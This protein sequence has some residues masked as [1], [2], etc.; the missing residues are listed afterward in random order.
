M[1]TKL[2][3]KY[4]YSNHKKQ[5]V[6]NLDNIKIVSNTTT[7]RLEKMG[8]TTNTLFFFLIVSKSR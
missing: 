2:K 1:S 7:K 5:N 4:R 3:N 8:E 6:I